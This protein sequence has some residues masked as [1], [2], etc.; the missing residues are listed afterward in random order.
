M[1]DTGPMQ[2]LSSELPDGIEYGQVLCYVKGNVPLVLVEAILVSAEEQA[3]LT[4]PNA[5]ENGW[6]E[7]PMYR[8][9]PPLADGTA[10][11]PIYL[12]GIARNPRNAGPNS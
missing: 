12:W 4:W 9:G 8:K 7:G 10:E 2:I 6:L 5:G 1:L 11:Q 3:A